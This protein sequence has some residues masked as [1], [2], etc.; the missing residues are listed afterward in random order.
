MGRRGVAVSVALSD[1]RRDG[2]GGWRPAGVWLAT[3]RHLQA[4]YLRGDA[5]LEAFRRRVL[6]DASPPIVDATHA[7]RGD[8]EDWARWASHA[9]SNGHD[10]LVREVD[11]EATLDQLYRREVLG[12]ARPRASRRPPVVVAE[13]SLDGL[14]GWK[15]RAP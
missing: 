8:W 3:P 12:E 4:R 5:S 11:P 6:A 9:L 15:V 10:R 7:L 13:L 14:G 1:L 2:E